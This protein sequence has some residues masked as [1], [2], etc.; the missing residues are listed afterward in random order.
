MEN[1]VLPSSVVDAGFYTC[2]VH[3]WANTGST[4]RIPQSVKHVWLGRFPRDGEMLFA[5]V[6]C[7]EM[8]RQHAVHA[9]RLDRDADAPCGKRDPV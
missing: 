8:S 3:T 5:Q 6:D 2:G 7:V 9:L 4:V 1:W